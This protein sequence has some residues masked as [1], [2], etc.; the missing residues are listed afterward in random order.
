MKN[1]FWG[2]IGILMAAA[3]MFVLLEPVVEQLSNVA[4]SIPQ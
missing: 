3:I 4:H 1:F 2:V